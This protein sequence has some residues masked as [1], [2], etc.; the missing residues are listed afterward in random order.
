MLRTVRARRGTRES[1]GLGTEAYKGK[2]S[3]T[4]RDDWDT[5]VNK[6]H[7]NRSMIRDVSVCVAEVRA[8]REGWRVRG[9]RR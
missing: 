6:P 8:V 9:R 7:A 3:D 2:I 4:Y 5:S 1:E